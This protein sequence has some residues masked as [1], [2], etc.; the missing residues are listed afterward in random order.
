MLVLTLWVC[1]SLPLEWPRPPS[2]SLSSPAWPQI[3]IANRGEIAVRVIRTCREL[4]IATVAVYSTADKQSLHVQMAD[5]A[6][7][8]G[9]P[10]SAKSYL[11][12]PNIL[13]ACVS[14]GAEAIHPGYGFLSENAEFADICASMGIN[15]IGPSSSAMT[16]MG[17][18]ATA[19][20]TMLAADVPCVPG[21]RGLVH[22]LDNCKEV[23]AA[24]GYPVML[25]ATAGGGGRG[26]K[27]VREEEGLDMA[28]KTCSTEAAA[29]FGNGGLYMEKFVEGPRHVE[30]QIMADKHGN[31][32]ALGERDCSIQRR[33]QK[34][35]EEAP[36]PALTEDLRRRMCEAAVDA[37]A[38]IDYV[39]AGT[40]E[41]LLET[42]SGEFY[43]ME[44]NT[45]L[46]VEHTVTECVTGYD[47]V[48]EQI[49][50]AE[51]RPLSFSQADV[52]L[53]GHAIQARINCEDPLHGFRP[54]PGLVSGF[55]APGG[56]GVRWDGHLAPFEDGYR[57][58][59]NYDSLLGK[60]IVWAPTR[61]QAVAKLRR[62]LAET[63]VVG[64]PTTINFHL[65]V[66][67]NPTFN[68]G[69][70]TTDFIETQD[71]ITTLKERTAAAKLN[72]SSS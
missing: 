39:G 57:I 27:I 21:S 63:I 43:F 18:K 11:C 30:I 45:R 10:E 29:A 1:L 40:V 70:F 69:Q 42:T 52:K 48:A 67:D 66:M 53:V 14:T 2:S 22:T 47:L 38:A 60:L 23:A 72:A 59:P 49:H 12:M 50:V 3:L 28:F 32:V 17:D 58:P 4:G 8:I 7:C 55:L 51:G 31:V 19:K 16:Q 26:I 24:T 61:E 62:A 36:S 37:A 15:F 6:V 68:S 9:P 5:E 56:L 46:Q 54:N 65:V 34:L 35:V 13:A 41:F 44:C 64:V 20:E 33:N 25:K 71:I